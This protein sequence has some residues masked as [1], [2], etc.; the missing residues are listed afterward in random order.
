VP[1]P[2]D[3]SVDPDQT[4]HDTAHEL[5]ATT[6][7]GLA[8]AGDGDLAV[9]DSAGATLEPVTRAALAADAAFTGTFAPLNGAWTAVSGGVGFQNSWVNFG[10]SYPAAR[11]RKVADVVTVEG[12]VKTGASGTVAF[13]LPAGSRP[14]AELIF[15]TRAD[16]GT[17]E[18]II[19]TDGDVVISG[20]SV[21]TFASLMG[22]SFSVL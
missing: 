17:A 5:I 20:G 12:M 19:Q 1:L 22:V 10:G 6:L 16:G 14:A 7:N 18:V 8:S 4:G 3:D 15:S 13:T 21:S 9:W 2:L 11:F